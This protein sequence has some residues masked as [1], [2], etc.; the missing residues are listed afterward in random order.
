MIWVLIVASVVTLSPWIVYF[1]Q[2][3]TREVNNRWSDL[4]LTILIPVRNEA[5]QLPRLIDDLQILG[6]IPVIFINDHSLD[7]SEQIIKAA[8]VKQKGWKLLQLA[9]GKTGKKTAILEGLKAANTSYVLTLDADVIFNSELLKYANISADLVIRPVR[10]NGDSFLSSVFAMEYN[11]FNAI[12]FVFF[13]NRPISASGANLLVRTSFYLEQLTQD[14]KSLAYSS[15]DDYFLL[16]YALAKEKVIHTDENFESF[17][18][19]T[20]PLTIK[21]YVQQR[22][23]WLSK[24]YA[25]TRSTELFAGIWGSIY[26]LT[27]MLLLGMLFFNENNWEIAVVFALFV[28]RLTMDDWILSRL[29][30]KTTFFTRLT[31]VIIHPF[32]LLI[33]VFASLFVHPKWKGR[34]VS[35]A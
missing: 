10:M 12:N 9:D 28:L 1:F 35:K 26:V 2:S 7:E 19:T 18:F 23:R 3:K 30:T 27:P 17:V 29:S 8:C 24:S 11:L 15:G 14:K 16:H 33:T 20:A 25:N 6:D 34:S 5:K 21:E 4:D 32:L 31:F 22:T 13:K